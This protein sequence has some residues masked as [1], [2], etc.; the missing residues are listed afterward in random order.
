M[1]RCTCQAAVQL[2]S[3]NLWILPHILCKLTVRA[4]NRLPP[5]CQQAATGALQGVDSNRSNAS[6]QS[7]TS[8]AAYMDTSAFHL[9]PAAARSSIARK[10]WVSSTCG[11]QGTSACG[12]IV[13]AGVWGP[14]LALRHLSKRWRGAARPASASAPARAVSS[15]FS[16]PTQGDTIVRQPSVAPVCCSS[17]SSCSELHSPP[18]CANGKTH[19]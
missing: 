17:S 4:S 7:S 9:V 8:R 2:V 6:C 18:L 15:H 3:S 14:S 12:S 19:R 16:D 10:K 13:A 1:R 11:C 5:G